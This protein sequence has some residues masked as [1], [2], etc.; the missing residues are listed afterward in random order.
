MLRHQLGLGD[1][2]FDREMRPFAAEGGRIV[3]RWTRVGLP[4]VPERF[5]NAVVFMFGQHPE[6]DD[7]VAGPGGTGVIIE[8]PSATLPGQYHKYIVS[9]KHVI[10]ETPWVR[11]NTCDGSTR[12]LEFISEDWV[13]DGK[14]DLA[15]IDVT[16]CLNLET[17]HYS[18]IEHRE[19]LS[20]SRV[21]G[22]HVG[23]GDQVFM[24]GLYSDHD[25]ST[26]NLPVARFGNIAAMPHPLVPVITG[27]GDPYKRP[28][29]LNDMRSR[30]GFS[31]SPV[32]VWRGQEVDLSDYD[33]GGRKFNRLGGSIYNR[34]PPFLCFAGI[35]RGQFP[36]KTHVLISKD[37]R[38]IR[39]GTEFT[40]ASAM[41]IVIPAWEISHLLDHPQLCAERD[42]RDKMDDRIRRSENAV[43]LRSD[44]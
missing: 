2:E 15:V 36:E 21:I 19:F 18:C 44:E 29:F 5:E 13:S 40:I 38:L 14:E 16:E 8:T 3:Q 11:L 4:R 28:A 17:D 35:H 42:A 12:M 1:L 23:I 34:T 20:S 33:A 27:P 30:Q 37:E 9:N 7:L 24:L 43:T 32:W 10:D 31:G 6:S 41:T 39:N 22:N 25:G 26:R